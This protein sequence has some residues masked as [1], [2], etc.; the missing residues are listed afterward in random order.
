MTP[1][2][3]PPSVIAQITDHINTA[4]TTTQENLKTFLTE[5]LA[6]L[7]TRLDRLEERCDHLELNQRKKHKKPKQQPLP[8]IFETVPP[9]PLDDGD[10]SVLST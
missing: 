9:P 2:A 6:T 5:A 4:I 1:P 8:Q 3:P 10:S 7:H